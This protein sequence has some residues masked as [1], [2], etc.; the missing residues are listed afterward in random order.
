MRRN[1]L[2]FVHSNDKLHYPPIH[3]HEKNIGQ[4]TNTFDQHICIFFCCLLDILIG[5]N[6][7][8]LILC[9]LAPPQ[10]LSDTLIAFLQPKWMTAVSSPYRGALSAP[11]AS[12][13]SRWLCASQGGKYNTR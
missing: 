9:L 11:C 3:L 10:I 4:R 8:I 6:I 2:S 5:V 7:N 1:I 12:P 13:V